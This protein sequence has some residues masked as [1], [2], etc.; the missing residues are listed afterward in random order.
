MLF[1]E[2]KFYYRRNIKLAIIVSQ[3]IIIVMFL[4]FPELKFETKLQKQYFEP[5]ITLIDIPSTAQSN[6]II[7]PAPPFASIAANENYILEEIEML[8]DIKIRETQSNNESQNTD[9]GVDKGTNDKVYEWSALPFIPRQ[10]LEVIPEKVDGGKGS[11]KLKL[12]IGKNGKVKQ[13]QIIKDA[14]NKSD[15]GKHVLKA[16]YGSKWQPVT[17][18]N[19]QIEYWLE[20]TYTFE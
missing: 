13:H 12:L 10:I 18:E 2:D 6:N 9:E 11:I 16:V 1:K 5:V 20:K 8:E 4:Y 17:I 7:P 14:T 15:C 19:S 3:I